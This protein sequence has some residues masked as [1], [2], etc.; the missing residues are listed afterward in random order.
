LNYRIEYVLVKPGIK[1]TI[2]HFIQR[3]GFEPQAN[4]I[5]NTMPS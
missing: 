5:P 1:D 3:E 4:E 2:R